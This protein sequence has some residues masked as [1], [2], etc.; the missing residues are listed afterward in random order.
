MLNKKPTIINTNLNLDDLKRRYDD[1][2]VS[3]II[4]NYRMLEFFGED[5]RTLK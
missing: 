4:G 5:V 3:R 1:R 2:V